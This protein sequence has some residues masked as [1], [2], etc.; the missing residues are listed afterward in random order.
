VELCEK[1][2]RCLAAEV[3]R[4]L[5]EAAWQPLPVA[6]AAERTILKIP[7]IPR[8][9]QASDDESKKGR[10]P[11]S[12]TFQ[13]TTWTFGEKLAMV[14]FSDEVV[15]DYARRLKQELD[16]SRLWISAYTNDVS[17]YVVSKRLLGEGGYEVRSSLSSRVTDGRPDQLNPAMEDRIVEAVK[18]LLPASF[19]KEPI[20]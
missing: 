20:R 2:G 7:R 5:G 15:V 1:H 11:S 4:L 16:G 13:I 6:L 18:S 9:K 10:K 8:A 12:E 14:F 3:S 19:G 17:R